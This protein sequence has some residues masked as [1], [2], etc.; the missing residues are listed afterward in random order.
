M[1]LRGPVNSW[2]VD[3]NTLHIILLM[4]FTI[5]GLIDLMGRDRE[6]MDVFRRGNNN[7]TGSLDIR[8]P[9]FEIVAERFGELLGIYRHVQVK[10]CQERC[11]NASDSPNLQ[12]EVQTLPST[13]FPTPPISGPP[14]NKSA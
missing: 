13:S 11:K 6:G 7:C 12:S 10:I 3:P 4:P 14:K 9:E 1:L 5:V 2:G 8:Y